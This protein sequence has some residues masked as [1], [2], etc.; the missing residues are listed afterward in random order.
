MSI[1]SRISKLYNDTDYLKSSKAPEL[2]YKM[3]PQLNKESQ[4]FYIV[5]DFHLAADSAHN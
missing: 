1:I 2:P 4:R 5:D 3:T